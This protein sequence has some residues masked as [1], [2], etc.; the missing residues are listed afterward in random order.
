MRLIAT[1]ARHENG[2]VAKHIAAITVCKATTA[3][4]VPNSLAGRGT[5]RG[6]YSLC[7]QTEGD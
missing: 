1:E 6:D 5:S 7:A 4:L 2:S 3:R